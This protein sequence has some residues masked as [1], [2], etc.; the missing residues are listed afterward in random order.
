ILGG[1]GSDLIEG[2][3]GDDIIDGDRYLS[4]SLSLR[5]AAN[6]GLELRRLN[7][8]SEIRNEL[9]AGT[10]KPS[11]LEI[12]KEI[13]TA[14][15][16]GVVDTAVFRGALA[17]YAIEGRAGLVPGVDLNG[18]GFIEISHQAGAGID[19]VDKVRNIER[20]QF[21]DQVV[22]LTPQSNTGPQG[23]A[24]ITGVTPAPTTPTE[25]QRLTVSLTGVTDLDNVSTANPTGAITG[26]ITVF[27][28]AET[29]PGVFADLIEPVTGAPITGLTFTP[30]D[31]EAGL[32]LRARIMYQDAEGVIETVYSAPSNPVVNVNDAATGT[33]VLSDLTP[34]QTVALTA[35]STIADPDVAGGVPVLSFQWQ[36]SLPLVNGGAFTNI[37]GATAATFTPTQAQVGG[38]LRVIASYTDPFGVVQTISAP[39]G[40]VGGFFNGAE[41]G[42]T[43]N[44]TAGADLINGNGGNDTINGLAG[45]DVIDG[46]S[47]NDTIDGGA[48][49][50]AMT[51]GTG[52]DTFVVD[53]QADTV[54][55]VAGGGTDAVRT[56]LA[57]YILP[58]N[59]ENL[60]FIGTGPFNGAGNALANIIVGA[61][62]ND[63]LDGGAGVDNLQG[64]GGDDTYYVDVATD[65]I[66]NETGGVDTVLSR[67]T[68][69]SLSTQ[70][71]TVE[72]LVFIGTGAFTGAG[73]TLDNRIVGGAAGD[74]LTGGGGNDTL[75]GGLG[76]DT[77]DGGA[78]NDTLIGGAGND[79]LI[80]GTGADIFV[81][82]P[83]SGLDRI[84]GFN[85]T[86]AP[87]VGGVVT[88]D[89]IDLTQF[90]ITAATFAATVQV[91]DRGNDAMLL[92]NGVE[93]ALLVGLTN[94][95]QA[96]QQA[97]FILGF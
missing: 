28:Q 64:F 7:S 73:N 69:F 23:L 24:A 30:D 66:T 63:I 68:T 36:V 15:A 44:G 50:D 92:V 84:E 57:N 74:T 97:D 13:K 61:A 3:G 20:L 18:D 40:V 58:E 35:R 49:V 46:G 43:T 11:Q 9:L 79:T 22:W 83:S 93:T 62:G 96:Q 87:G 81:L 19:G 38:L 5:S 42:Q 27:W 14:T 31:G 59:V 94:H 54:I 51:G 77:L 25:G 55:E 88:Q 75:E 33:V 6:P 76:N 48:G 21:A 80:G 8:I 70:A 10:I 4:V 45:D 53:N 60:T 72:N 95:T 32:R 52:N 41:T 29:A 82:G 26:T 71:T 12:V 2:R 90:G 1:G 78:Q 91:V 17:E 47:G 56:T 65:R 39:S 85:G 86:S 67:S 34:T 37:A 89:R 16:P